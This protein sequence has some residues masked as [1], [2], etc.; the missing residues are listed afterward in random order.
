MES[1]GSSSTVATSTVAYT[2]DANGNLTSAVDSVKKE[3]LRY[4]YDPLGQLVSYQA[5]KD[6]SVVLDQKNSYNGDGQR[7]SRTEGKKETAYFYQN[8]TLLMSEDGSGNLESFYYLGVSANPLAVMSKA[9]DGTKNY[10][11]YQKDI[12]GS[13]QAVTNKNGSCVEWYSYTDFGE[14]TIHEEQNGFENVICYTGGV[15]DEST[16]LYY[17]NARYYD[18]ETG[19]FLS[20]DTYRGEAEK[21]DTLHLYLYCAN[22]PVNY[23]DPSGHWA[24]ALPLLTEYLL[25]AGFTYAVINKVYNVVNS[26]KYK[27]AVNN[28]L[29]KIKT[30][31]KKA[32]NDITYALSLALANAICSTKPRKNKYEYHHIVA[33]AA[34]AAKA[35]LPARTIVNRLLAK[36]V[37]NKKN[38]VYI[39]YSLHRHL[40]TKIYYSSVNAVVQNADKAGKSKNA[41]KQNVEYSLNFLKTILTIVSVNSP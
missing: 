33:K 21:P 17:L 36:G 20:R 24:M 40:H 15:Y 29:N 37:E 2:Y 26:S 11:T 23:V 22:N 19:R 9:S 30:E 18:P 1:A 13:T 6:G 12:Q 32:M 3:E 4:Q 38:K 31:T 39:K 41:K 10:Y 16:S 5:K 34:K 25:S 14:T 27:Q 28:I 35:A 7:I 8:G